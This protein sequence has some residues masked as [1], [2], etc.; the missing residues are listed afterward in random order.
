MYARRTCAGLAVALACAAAAVG[1]STS[2]TNGIAPPN[3][4]LPAPPQPATA[5]N[6]G[7]APGS[8]GAAA[9]GSGPV[10]N[11]APGAGQV[12]VKATAPVNDPDAARAFVD[13]IVY[14]QRSQAA[15]L[16]NDL[17]QAQLAPYLAP[18]QLRA[19]RAELAADR[20]AGRH[21]T[22]VIAISPAVERVQGR[23]ATIT[24]CLDQSSSLE[25]DR[26]GQ[27]RPVEPALVRL[28]VTMTRAA[29]GRWTVSKVVRG[30]AC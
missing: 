17:E 9:P 23:S 22:G 15:A 4:T 24:D 16:T 6:G 13:Y 2:G 1:C 19:V 21:T 30:S 7:S 20:R 11:P 26:A 3:P 10:V 29:S 12:Q 28:T 5:Q 18:A 14:W 25:V 8:P 27:A